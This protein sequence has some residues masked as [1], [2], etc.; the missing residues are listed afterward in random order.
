MNDKILQ[1]MTDWNDRFLRIA[2]SEVAET[3]FV[4]YVRNGGCVRWT[5]HE[6]FVHF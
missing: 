1:P 2:D 3:V 6:P 5:I 4:A